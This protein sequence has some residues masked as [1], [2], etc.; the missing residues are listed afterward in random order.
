VEYSLRVTKIDVQDFPDFPDYVMHIAW[1]ITFTDANGNSYVTTGG[2]NFDAPTEATTITP[3]S[4]L[5]EEQVRQWCVTK[6]TNDGL[7]A[8]MEAQAAVEIEKSLAASQERSLPWES[9]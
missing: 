2:N 1:E 4:D 6:I 3:F 8:F 5:T 9:A 7:L